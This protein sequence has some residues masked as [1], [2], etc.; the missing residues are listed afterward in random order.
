LFIW[1]GAV[2]DLVCD[3]RLTPWGVYST[4]ARSYEKPA[5]LPFDSYADF[6]VLTDRAVSMAAAVAETYAYLLRQMMDCYPAS[7]GHSMTS[8]AVV[9]L[10]R[11]SPRSA[12]R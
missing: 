10:I 4:E 12:T 2:R 11:R 1:T 9:P 7:E 3:S 5:R 8:R 6:V